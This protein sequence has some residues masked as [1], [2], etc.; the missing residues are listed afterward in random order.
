MTLCTG[1]IFNPEIQEPRAG[2]KLT[3]YDLEGL[4]LQDM[5]RSV[6][7]L[8]ITDGA[9]TVTARTMVEQA[10]GN[11]T[12]ESYTYDPTDLT[13]FQFAAK[14]GEF[15]SKFGSVA[16]AFPMEHKSGGLGLHSP[17]HDPTG[18]LTIG[19]PDYI[20]SNLKSEWGAQHIRNYALVNFFNPEIDRVSFQ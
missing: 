20:I 13:I 19:T 8:Q 2:T 12:L 16:G 17:L 15:A 3:K 11:R 14:V 5:R 6:A 9:D 18:Q 1:W 4:T 10:F 7:L